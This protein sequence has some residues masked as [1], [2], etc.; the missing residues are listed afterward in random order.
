MKGFRGWFERGYLPHRD[1][2]GLVQF[3]TFRLADSLPPHLADLR[4]GPNPPE[5]AREK[6]LRFE[7]SLDRGT[8]VCHLRRPA[9]GI[10]MVDTLKHFH[11]SRYNLLAWVV[12]PNHVHVLFETGDCPMAETIQAWK[13]VSARKINQ[14]LQQSG[15]V[16]AEDY[17]DTYMRNPGQVNQARKYIENNPA[18]ARLVLNPAD[19]PWSSARFRDAGGEL[20]L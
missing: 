18:K 8:G 14:I 10:L 20:R 4:S 17:W 11:A 15:K 5:E 7:A 12:M 9:I 19:W 6:Q 3:V 13:S 1:E 2:P 16:W